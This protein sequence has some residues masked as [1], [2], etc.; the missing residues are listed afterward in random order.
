MMQVMSNMISNAVKFSHKGGTVTVGCLDRKGKTTIFVKDEGMGIPDGS[1]EKVFGKFLQIDSSDRRQVGGTGLGMSISKEIIEQFKGKID[2]I[3]KPG[4][5][6]TFFVELPT[7][8]SAVR[9][10][11]Q[12]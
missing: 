11:E 9:H 6:T 1:R 5:G 3:S 2:Y 4:S 7:H 10:L 12:A 8:T